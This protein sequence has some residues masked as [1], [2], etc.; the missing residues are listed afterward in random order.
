MLEEQLDFGVK[1]FRDSDNLLLCIISGRDIG[2]Y[3]IR[4]RWIETL[5]V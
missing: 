5:T 1:K 3:S 4:Y 2:L